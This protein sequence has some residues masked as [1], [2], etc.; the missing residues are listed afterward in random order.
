MSDKLSQKQLKNTRV[1]LKVIGTISIF[2]GI[3]SS[4][5]APLEL[6]CFYLF[7]EGGRFHYEGFGMGSFMFAAISFQIVA[8]Y[9]I[10]I[11]FLILGYG[12]LKPKGWIKSY[13]LILLKFW[14]VVGLP[15]ITVVIAFTAMTK[16]LSIYFGMLFCLVLISLYFIFPYIL[17]RFYNSSQLDRILLLD[18]NTDHWMNRLPERILIT[19]LIYIFYGLC[20]HIPIFFHGIFPFFGIF[21]H[22]FEGVMFIELTILILVVLIWGTLK[23]KKWA[24]WGS[25]AFLLIWMIS[26]IITFMNNSYSDMLAILKFPAREMNAF[27]GMPLQGYHFI[28]FFGIPLVVTIH[29]VYKSKK[30]YR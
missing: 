15:L 25:I 30:Y 16:S 28:I 17:L 13:S 8:Y 21:L 7:S 11:I 18:N 24:W 19:S 10:G 6:Y 22:N 27:Q 5:I 26:F 23:Q 1:I 12:H 2:V 14:L 3:I 9:L 4:L 29:F 20:L